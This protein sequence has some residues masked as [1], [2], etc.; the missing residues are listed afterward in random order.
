MMKRQML[1][2]IVLVIGFS[3]VVGIIFLRNK[4]VE[5]TQPP[6]LLA[7]PQAAPQTPGIT[8]RLRETATKLI[9][10][11]AARHLLNELAAREGKILLYGKL[12]DQDG[13]PIPN[14]E[15]TAEVHRFPR[16]L[17]EFDND[18]TTKTPPKTILMARSDAGGNFVLNGGH[19]GTGITLSLQSSNYITDRGFWVYD[20]GTDSLTNRTYIHSETPEVFVLWR[21]S[22]SG[23]LIPFNWRLKIR[24]D[25]AINPVSTHRVNLLGGQ[26]VFSQS[27]NA[28]FWVYVRPP[29]GEADTYDFDLLIE[30]P[31]G[32]FSEVATNFPYR[33]PTSGYIEKLRWRVKTPPGDL[34]RQIYVHSRKN[35]VVASLRLKVHSAHELQISGLISPYGSTNLQPDEAMMIT[36]PDEI[37][38]WDTKLG[39]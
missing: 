7:P 37:L 13:N 33:A 28:D 34:E 20:F 32:G 3:A 19:R 5:T 12:Q 26:F 23:R 36:D 25:N 27:T 1:F 24:E 16:T 31:N 30:A 29:E 6:V 18:P 17:A 8:G 9:P 35:R 11:A 10:G 39:L 21:R 22:D 2:P 38:S 4:T 14:F 15:V